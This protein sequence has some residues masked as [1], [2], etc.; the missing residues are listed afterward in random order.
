[1]REMQTKII[2]LP[3]RRRNPDRTAAEIRALRREIAALREQ[4]KALTPPAP[5][6]LG[7]RP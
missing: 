5:W 2:P 3:V 6:G 4:V 7:G 1:M